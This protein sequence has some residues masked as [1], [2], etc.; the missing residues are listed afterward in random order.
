MRGVSM[1]IKLGRVGFALAT[2]AYALEGNTTMAAL[3][4]GVSLLAQI[5]YGNQ[6]KKSTRPKLTRSRI[7]Q[8]KES[9]K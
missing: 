3:S 6:V 5:A 1:L 2:I 9:A 8:R 7:A 4:L